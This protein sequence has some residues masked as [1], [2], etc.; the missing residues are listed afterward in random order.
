MSTLVETLREARVAAGEII[1]TL[2]S[3]REISFPIAAN[4]RL[5][6]ASAEQLRRIEIS[7]L[8]IHWPGLDEDLSVQG[9]VRGDYDKPRSKRPL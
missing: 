9:I 3:G 8:G 1:P 5:A 2:E 4:P 7:P 6:A